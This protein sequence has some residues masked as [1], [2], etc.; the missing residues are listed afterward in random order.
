MQGVISFILAVSLL[1][2][3]ACTS[4]RRFVALVT[5][6]SSQA[7][8]LLPPE[9]SGHKGVAKQKVTMNVDDKRQ[10]FIVLTQYAD[11]SYQVLIMLPTGQT[12]LSMRYDGQVLEAS[13]RT[14][15]ALPTQEM[16]AMMQFTSW[17]EKAI[18]ERY[19]QALGWDVLTQPNLRQ[20]LVDRKPLLTVTY[21]SD[22][23]IYIGHF[24]QKYQVTIEPLEEQQ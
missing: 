13:N 14:G 20:L 9:L 17:P 15:I 3:P 2:L 7:L 23:V 5:S 8:L 10:T 18:K 22:N 6:D 16:M 11:D 1:S 24:L 4:L 19:T 21:T 12:V